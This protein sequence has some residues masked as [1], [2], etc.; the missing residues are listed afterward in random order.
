M[1]RKKKEEPKPDALVAAI[2]SEPPAASKPQFAPGD[3]IQVV[4][5]RHHKLANL[6]IVHTVDVAGLSCYSPGKNGAPDPWRIEP[7]HVRVCGRALLKYGKPLPDDNIHPD[8]IN[9]V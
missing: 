5:R 6:G 2:K 1:A 9:D 8:R 7:Q 4:S 3:I